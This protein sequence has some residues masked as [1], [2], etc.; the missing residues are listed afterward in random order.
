MTS[1]P[2]GFGGYQSPASI[3]NKAAEFFGR[4]LDGS[5]GDEVR[6]SLD[7]NII[8]SGH[9]AADLL[10]M[11]EGGTLSLCYFSTSCPES[12]PGGP[13]PVAGAGEKTGQDL[14]HR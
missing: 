4:H 5:L 11:V 1:I 12:Q 3:H 8:E 14:I 2:I 6:F 10:T 13:Q 7:G 9:K